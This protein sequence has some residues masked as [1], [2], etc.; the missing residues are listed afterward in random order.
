VGEPIRLS[1]VPHT[2]DAAAAQLQC[3][4]DTGRKSHMGSRSR[5]Y[6]RDFAS[7]DRLFDFGMTRIELAL[8]DRDDKLTAAPFDDELKALLLSA[9]P[10]YPK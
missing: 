4:D 1:R 3:L 8:V 6:E 2:G 5:V 10:I 9:A 7:K